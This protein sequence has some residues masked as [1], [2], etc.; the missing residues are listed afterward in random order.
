LIFIKPRFFGLLLVGFYA[1]VDPSENA[2]AA[3]ISTGL[4]GLLAFTVLEDRG[5]FAHAY[6][7]HVLAQS[8]DG[9]SVWQE[10]TAQRCSS[11]ND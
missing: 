4:E 2:R 1:A 10:G 9:A 8:V 5:W 3:P 6:N 7:G 11:D